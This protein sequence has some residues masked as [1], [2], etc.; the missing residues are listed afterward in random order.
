VIARLLFELA[1]G[2]LAGSVVGR[3]FQ[4]GSALL[5]VTRLLDTDRLIAFYH[6]KPAWERHILIVPKRPI[7]SLLHLARPEHVVS[8]TDVLQAAHTLVQSP[9]LDGRGYVLCA[10][11]GPRQEVGQV[12]F[13]LFTGASYV[14]P[15]PVEIASP[16]LYSDDALAIVHHPQPT[17]E[18]HLVIVPCPALPPLAALTVE[19]SVRL[20]RALVPLAWLDQRFDLVTRGYTLYLQEDGATTHHPLVFHIVAGDQLAAA[21]A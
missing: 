17:W 15:L 5:P 6:P 19:A 11:G 10:N 3:G 2:P 20:R 18:T 13:H 1:K 21:G 16:P 12:H 7:P 4:Y 8:F 14:R 9:A